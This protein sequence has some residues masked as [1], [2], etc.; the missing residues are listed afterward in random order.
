MASLRH[1]NTILFMGMCPDPPLLVME[2]CA[3]G[4]LYDLLNAGSKDP[5]MAAQLTWARRLSIALDAA[6]VRVEHQPCVRLLDPSC[7][8]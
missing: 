7:C 5:A 6:K 8:S 1:P 2:W 4:S 3:R